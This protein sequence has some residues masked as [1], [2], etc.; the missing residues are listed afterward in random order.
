VEPGTVPLA[1]GGVRGVISVQ[2]LILISP[3]LHPSR[4]L[5][6]PLLS[7]PH[8]IPPFIRRG[9]VHKIYGRLASWGPI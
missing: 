7:F 4:Y 8:T 5:S 2:S 9:L 3:P 1:V 6:L